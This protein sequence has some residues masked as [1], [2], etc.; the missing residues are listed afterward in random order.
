[1]LL[2]VAGSQEYQTLASVFKEDL[3]KIGVK[4]NIESV[5]WSLMLKRVEDR[6]FDSV[7]LGWALTWTVDPYQIWH[8]SQADVP[9]GSNSVGFRNKE[10]DKLIEDLRRTFDVDERIKKLRRF[11]QIVHEE[12]P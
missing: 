5:E 12:Q 4:L 2:I 6:N 9:K 8:S 3:L 10:A 11:H 7:L 1:G